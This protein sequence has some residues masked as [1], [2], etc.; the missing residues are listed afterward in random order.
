MMS[1]ASL[2]AARAEDAGFKKLQVTQASPS[3]S[4]HQAAGA[5]T[6]IGLTANGDI[7]FPWECRETI[8]KQRGP[9]SVSVPTPSND[10]PS[11]QQSPSPEN[12]GGD[13]VATVATVQPKAE[14]KAEE[15]TGPVV[16]A[17]EINAASAQ[18][19]QPLLS[20]RVSKPGRKGQHA[21]LQSHQVSGSAVNAK[22][23]DRVAL[24]P[25]AAQK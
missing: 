19:K 16:S 13:A 23:K 9:I 10:P 12:R 1:V 11:H 18:L 8:E 7:V 20:K 22:K 14:A 3:Q 15:M 2:S 17:P 24:Q 4:G 5:C 21:A 25:G 6:P